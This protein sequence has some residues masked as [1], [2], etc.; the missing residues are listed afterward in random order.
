M[1]ELPTVEDLA[2]VAGVLGLLFLMRFALALRRM[3][4]EAGEPV[5]ILA[6]ARHVRLAGAFG[7]KREPERRHAARQLLLGLVFAFAGLAIAGGMLVA[8]VLAP[9]FSRASEIG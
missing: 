7:E 9:F 2:L 6:D 3:R 4:V 8:D 5:D 1:S